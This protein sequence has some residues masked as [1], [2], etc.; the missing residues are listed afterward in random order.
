MLRRQAIGRRPVAIA[1]YCG[2]W[3]FFSYS[4]QM[5]GLIQQSFSRCAPAAVQKA[6]AKKEKLTE[7]WGFPGSRFIWPFLEEFNAN[8]PNARLDVSSGRGYLHLFRRKS[9]DSAWARSGHNRRRHDS[10]DHH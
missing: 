3:L 1:F 9:D 8:N 4:I 7:P 10:G 6:G 2:G 5:L